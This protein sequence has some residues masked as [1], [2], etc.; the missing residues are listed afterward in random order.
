MPNGHML[1]V[2]VL[3]SHLYDGMLETIG[4]ALLVGLKVSPATSELGRAFVVLE[5]KHWIGWLWE[6]GLPATASCRR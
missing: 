1:Y 5:C 4:E 3:F 6:R 2:V